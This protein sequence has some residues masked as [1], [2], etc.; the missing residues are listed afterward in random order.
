MTVRSRGW[1]WV[2]RVVAATSAL[3][4]VATCALLLWLLNPSDVREQAL[5]AVNDDAAVALSYH[6]GYVSLAPANGAVREAVVFYPG[7]HAAARAYVPRWAPIVAATGTM[8][9]IPDVPLGLAFLDSAAAD[10]IMADWPQVD[11]WWLG[12]HSLGGVAATDHLAAHPELDVEGLVLW[13]AFPDR[14]ADLAGLDLDVL[15]VTGSRDEIVA[16][17]EV[18]A[19]LDRLPPGTRTVEIDGMEHSQFGAYDSF[20]GDGDPAISDERAQSLLASET[21][22][23]LADRG[24]RRTASVER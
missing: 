15:A 21:A 14:D 23:F 19:S 20:F 4:L 11:R 9:L 12:G 10:P 7:G 3:V 18:R 13:A 2:R 8:V 22:D 6:D 1:R 17:Q 5:A 24:S 16:T